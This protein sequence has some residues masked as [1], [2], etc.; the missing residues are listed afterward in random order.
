MGKV[1]RLRFFM[2]EAFADCED[3]KA[4]LNELRK[5]GEE[6]M[7]LRMDNSMQLECLQAQD[8]QQTSEAC[9]KWVE[10]LG[11]NKD[12]IKNMLIASGLGDQSS[13]DRSSGQSSFFGSDTSARCVDPSNADPESWECDCYEEA[14]EACDRVEVEHTDLEC[15][16][17]HYCNFPDV[18]Q[19]WKD[20]FCTAALDALRSALLG[21]ASS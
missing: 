17:A 19:T 15:L 3:H 9:L 6:G 16:R 4:C 11:K 7:R 1:T 13:F 8:P 20:Q 5:H 10:C 21:G 2:P 12:T 18:C 14:H